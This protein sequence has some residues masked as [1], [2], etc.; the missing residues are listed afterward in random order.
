M[1]YTSDVTIIIKHHNINKF[2]AMLVEL[3]IGQ[4]PWVKGLKNMHKDFDDWKWEPE[5]ILISVSGWKWYDRYDVV[6]WCNELWTYFEE[7][8]TSHQYLHGAYLRI[9]EDYEDIEQKFINEGYELAEI[10]REI[11]IY[12]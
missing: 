12:E 6:T 11:I 1:G 8:E 10:S 4:L 2:R 9:G 5:G 3:M 7:K